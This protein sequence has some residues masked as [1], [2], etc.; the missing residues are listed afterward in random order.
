MVGRLWQKATES[1]RKCTPRCATVVAVWALI[2]YIAPADDKMHVYD[3]FDVALET[4]V[5][6]HT[7][8]YI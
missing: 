6:A 1:R 4:T 5:C 3:L 2:K 8:N 7:I